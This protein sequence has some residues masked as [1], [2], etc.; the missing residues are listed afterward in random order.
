MEGLPSGEVLGKAKATMSGKGDSKVY[1]GGGG[2][3]TERWLS[4]GDSEQSVQAT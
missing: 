1:R 3:E 4:F 2:A